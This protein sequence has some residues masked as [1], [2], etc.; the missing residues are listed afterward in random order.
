M[1]AGFQILPAASLADGV[2][3]LVFSNFQFSSV[4]TTVTRY[5]NRLVGSIIYSYMPAMSCIRFEL[6]FVFALRLKQSIL[7]L[8]FILVITE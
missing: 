2:T 5:A 1:K 6:D 8:S 7:L 4:K 3:S